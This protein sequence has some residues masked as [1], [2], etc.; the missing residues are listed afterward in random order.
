MVLEMLEL[1][2]R[3]GADLN[4]Q[5]EKG[6]TALMI[7]VQNDMLPLVKWFLAHHQGSGGG[8]K[9]DNISGRFVDTLLCNNMGY[10]LLHMAC[11]KG[12]PSM[13]QCL[14]RQGGARKSPSAGAFLPGKPRRQPV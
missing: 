10:S 5:D 9:S 14:V 4:A 12:N 13:V 1:L 2:W 11:I 8:A 3:H 6:N 7:A